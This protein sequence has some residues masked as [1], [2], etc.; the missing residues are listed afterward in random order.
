[1]NIRAAKYKDATEVALLIHLAIKDIAE[2]LTGEKEDQKI[3]IALAELFTTKG[4]R[5]SYE[6]IAVA[7]EAGS[8]AGII[9]AYS[10]SDAKRLDRPIINQLIKKTGNHSATL[11]KEADAG[12]FY[13]DTLSVH[14][15]Y[16]GQGIGTKLLSYFSEIAIKKGHEI[17]SLNVAQNNYKARA[18]YE[19][20][21]YQK[22]KQIIINEHPY[23]YMVKNLSNKPITYGIHSNGH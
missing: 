18:L 9:I 20:L 11:D 12:D 16:Q 2:K 7:E 21:G 4:N 22:K 3:Q 15:V 8:V 5:L 23:D 1:M 17:I 13:L 19:K 6:N 10:G 14:P